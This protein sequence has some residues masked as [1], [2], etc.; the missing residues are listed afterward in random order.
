M[1]DDQL[2]VDVRPR[3]P[4]PWARALL[5]V[6]L[7]VSLL[8]FLWHFP[9]AAVRTFFR[10]LIE[11]FAYVIA[12]I[13]LIGLTVGAFFLIPP[14]FVARGVD[15]QED[16]SADDAT[17]G[18]VR[19]GRV[20]MVPALRDGEHTPEILDLLDDLLLELDSTGTFV[21]DEKA[22]AVTV[23][24]EDEADTEALLDEAHTRLQEEGVRARLPH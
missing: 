5:I 6:V 19:F 11:G 7:Y 23:F 2:D 9:T 15:E 4:Y 13:A 3:K 8:L 22:G 20:L 24:G 14:P 18:C 10:N 12:G 16:A 1:Q 21:I 17:V